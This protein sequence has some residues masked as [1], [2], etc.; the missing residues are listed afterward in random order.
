MTIGRVLHTGAL[1]AFARGSLYMAALLRRAV[2]GDVVLAVPT[3]ALA[4]AWA[5]AGEG[6]Y[7]LDLLMSLPVVTVVAMNESAARAVGELLAATNQRD[8]VAGH[9]AYVSAEQGWPILT[10]DA[11][12]V[13]AVNPAADIDEIP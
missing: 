13:R 6:R 4:E 3:G 9:T 5:T 11:N 10:T 1:S 12:R 7:R 8:T 2:D